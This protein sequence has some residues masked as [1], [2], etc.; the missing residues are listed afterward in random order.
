M[1]GQAAAT[2][3]AEGRVIAVRDRSMAVAVAA[4]G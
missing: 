2:V 1:A 3:V 4:V